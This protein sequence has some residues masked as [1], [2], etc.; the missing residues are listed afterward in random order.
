MLLD[1]YMPVKIVSGKNC[2]V[3]NGSKI[4]AFGKKCIIVSGK[5]SAVKSGALS[6]ML[7]VLEKYSIEYIIFDEIEPNPET[8]TCKKAGD[9]AREYGADFVVGIG[10]GSVLDASKAV[11]IFALNPELTHS[12]IYERV[13]LAKHLPVVLVGTTAGTGSEVTGVSVLTNSDTGLKKS[14]S[15]ADCYADISFC[16]YRYTLSA[17]VDTRISTALDAFAHSIEAYVASSSNDLSEAYSLKALALLADFL[18]TDKLSGELDDEA[19]EK[20]YVASLYGGLAINIAGTCF[21]HTVGYYLTEN[22]NIPHG[23]A[24]AAFIGELIMRAKKYCP[25]KLE[26][27]LECMN[28]GS[29][30]LVECIR[31]YADVSLTAHG[32]ELSEIALRWKSGVKNF[33][34]TPGGYTYEDACRNLKEIIS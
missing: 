9:A 34:R 26:A 28:T 21:C 24:C 29:D 20:L 10:G 3:E 12:G 8:L 22:Y 6:D 14:I 11:A 7:K 23:R 30:E 19:Y 18:L 25:R 31:K 16:D 5:S 32:A 17:S 15:G 27:I 4:S 1:S 2:L 33:D 13:A